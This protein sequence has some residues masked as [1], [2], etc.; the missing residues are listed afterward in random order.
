[1]SG[2]Q[3]TRRLTVSKQSG[4]I[5]ADSYALHKIGIQYKQPIPIPDPVSLPT[6]WVA[7]SLPSDDTFRVNLSIETSVLE[8]AKVRTLAT[9][10]EVVDPTASLSSMFNAGCVPLIPYQTSTILTPVPVTTE[11]PVIDHNINSVPLGEMSLRDF[12]GD[13]NDPFETTAL[14]AIDVFSELQSV[15]QP[16]LVNTNEGHV[17]TSQQVPMTTE[18]TTPSVLTS[19]RPPLPNI[20]SSPPSFFPP[21]STNAPI[22][23]RNVSNTTRRPPVG[24]VGVLVDFGIGRPEEELPPYPVVSTT[25]QSTTN[26][27]T[28]PQSISPVPFSNP[29]RVPPPVRPKPHIPLTGVPDR[30]PFS[31]VPVLPPINQTR[32]PPYEEDHYVTFSSTS[33]RSSST[34]QAIDHYTTFSTTPQPSSSIP[35]VRGYSLPDIRESLTHDEMENLLS[36]STMGFPA[37]RVARALKQCGG[38]KQKALD[39][40]FLINEIEEKGHSGDSAETALLSHEQNVEKSLEYLKEVACYKEVWP[41]E[42]IHDAYKTAG[43]DWNKTIDILTQGR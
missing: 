16:E 13:S 18:S 19:P 7:P 40:L 27:T 9:A 17:N 10:G 41:E 24:G 12:E 21:N 29:G 30:S 25:G 8:Q 11:N 14:Q 5:Y 34:P 2:Y 32:P 38:D 28:Y 42:S 37:P 36:I 20:S 15:L 22:G 6:G 1:M 23:S 31:G 4:P 39:F 3:F 43:G 26:T 33:S 35:R